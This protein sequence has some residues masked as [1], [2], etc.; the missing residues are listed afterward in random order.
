MDIARLISEHSWEIVT[1]VGGS[2]G[3]CTLYLFRTLQELKNKVHIFERDLLKIERE[4]IVEI[5]E[6]LSEIR[7]DIKLLLLNRR[8]G[9]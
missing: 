5:K 1:F 2:I 3:A 8:S 7:Q 6:S 9:D 4:V